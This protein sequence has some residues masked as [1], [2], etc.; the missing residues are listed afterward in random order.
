M[1]PGILEAEAVD[2]D[3][4]VGVF[5]GVGGGGWGEEGEL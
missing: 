4:C 2:L 5:E 3:A 1:V